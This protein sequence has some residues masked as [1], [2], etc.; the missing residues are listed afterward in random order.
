MEVFRQ[1]AK[2]GANNVAILDTV[3]GELTGANASYLIDEALI[4]SLKFL[5]E[6]EF[7][8][9]K[10]APTLKIIGTAQGITVP[11]ATVTK[12]VVEK[13][14]VSDWDILDTF[15]GQKK[16]V[17]PKAYVRQLCHT[18]SKWLPV[19][20][21]IREAGMSL[22]EALELLDQEPTNAPKRK[23]RQIERVKAGVGPLAPSLTTYAA[24]RGDLLA[25]GDVDIST[26]KKAEVFLKGVRTLTVSD[27]DLTSLLPLMKYCFDQFYASERVVG[28]EIRYAASHVDIECF[29]VK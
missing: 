1:V 24:I 5:R 14:V 10:G 15:L 22:A 20:Y 27:I 23:D 8:E 18:E 9:K 7:D 26:P 12:T 28:T 6:G 13:S 29:R 2:A 3:T 17:N 19:Y 21:F 25:K 16:A 4:P 11:G